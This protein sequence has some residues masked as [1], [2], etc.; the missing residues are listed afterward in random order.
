MKSL[1]IQAK[2]FAH[3]VVKAPVFVVAFGAV[4]FAGCASQNRAPVEFTP[5]SVSDI[6]PVI[7]TFRT[8]V[9]NKGDSNKEGS[10][11]ERTEH[12]FMWMLIRN[13]DRIEV[14]RADNGQSEIWSRTSNDLWYY[15]KAFHDDQTV[16]QYS[17]VDLKTLGIEPQWLNA[18]TAVNTK[19]MSAL[20]PGRADKPALGYSSAKFKGQIDGTD[21]SVFWLKDIALPAEIIQ[22][23]EQNEINTQLI[24]VEALAQ[25]DKSFSDIQSYRLIDY[26]DLGDMERD[27]FVR[28]IQNTLPA[29]HAHGHEH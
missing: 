3:V 16:V 17:P 29:S 4:H 24:S 8:H 13:S 10:N 26:S 5:A 28:K 14:K 21:Y 27:P 18:A 1:I 15:E 12:E 22:T 9:S 2:H 20:N 19:I 11:K 23:T 25:S 7:A 6:T